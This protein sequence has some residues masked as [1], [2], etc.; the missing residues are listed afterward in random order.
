MVSADKVDALRQKNTA[1]LERIR[2]IIERG[3]VIE[4]GG[5]AVES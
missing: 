1:V 5:G 3:R 2:R 4:K